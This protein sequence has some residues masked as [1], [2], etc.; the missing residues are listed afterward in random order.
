MKH[1][2]AL[3]TICAALLF[4]ST[5]YAADLQVGARF[6]A[7]FNQ[8]SGPND[9]AGEPTLLSG[10]AYSGMG[11]GGGIAAVA[12]L[13][14]TSIG[15][16]YLETNLLYVAHSATGTARS[17]S[18]NQSRT[19]GLDSNTLHIPLLLGIKSYYFCSGAA[20]GVTYF[21]LLSSKIK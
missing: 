13:S 12:A 8:L 1:L 15:I 7:G 6:V 3:G 16:L 4:A 17:A 10:A 19:V 21:I 14:N 2:T 20:I 11:F 5:T 18:G 9:P